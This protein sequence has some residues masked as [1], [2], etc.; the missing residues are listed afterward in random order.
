LLKNAPLCKQLKVQRDVNRWRRY[1]VQG[2]LLAT[3]CGVL[4]KNLFLTC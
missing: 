2:M 3:L 4:E 1:D